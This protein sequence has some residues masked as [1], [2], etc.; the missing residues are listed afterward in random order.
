MYELY[1]LMK[2]FSPEKMSLITFHQMQQGIFNYIHFAFRGDSNKKEV[3][4][5]AWTRA[6]THL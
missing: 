4:R 2:P 3:M 1:H 5:K 6:I